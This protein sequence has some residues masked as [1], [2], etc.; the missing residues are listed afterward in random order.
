MSLVLRIALEILIVL[1]TICIAKKA[2]AAVW[3]VFIM[4]T[5]PVV[6]YVLIINAKHVPA[7][8]IVIAPE[9]S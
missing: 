4:I 3:S 5:V 6:K 7:R 1:M 9:E 2:A 8:S